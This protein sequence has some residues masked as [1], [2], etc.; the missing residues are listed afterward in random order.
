MW[1]RSLAI[2]VRLGVPFT[3]GLALAVAMLVV[4]AVAVQWHCWLQW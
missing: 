1:W 2:A 4:V 3:V